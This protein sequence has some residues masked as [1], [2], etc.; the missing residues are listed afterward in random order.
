M[1]EAPVVPAQ[2]MISIRWVW[3]VL[4]VLLCAGGWYVSMTLLTVSGGAAPPGWLEALCRA[5]ALP[6][7]AG[8][9]E[10]V[11]RSRFAFVQGGTAPDTERPTVGTPWAVLGAAYF[12]F[13]GVWFLFVGT[14]SRGQW[15]WHLIPLTVVLAGAAASS[16]LIYVMASELKRWCGGCLVVHGLNA[17]LLL[18]AL[19]AAPWRKERPA[20]PAHPRFALAAATLLAGLA[21]WQLHLAQTSRQMLAVGAESLNK[22]Y[23]AIITDPD[24]AR[25]SHSRATRHEELAAAQASGDGAAA[26]HV[27][28]FIDF[29][30]EMCARAHKLLSDLQRAYGERLSVEYRHYPLDQ[31][32]NA[33]VSRTV[34]PAGCAAAQA[35]EAARMAGGEAGLAVFIDVLYRHQ[36]ELDSQ[37]FE[38]WAAE[39]QL[40]P[41]AFAAALQSAQTLQRVRQDVDVAARVGV[42]AAPALF[43]D[44]RKVEYWLNDAAWQA[45]LND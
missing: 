41:E 28:A 44:G 33:H 37:R 43:L 16:Y 9:C 39:A 35:A 21:V 31:A 22:R 18:A 23:L 1:S 15:L 24:F 20:R 40:D 13:V 12:A 11:L 19:A 25:W 29:Q 36:R 45:L 14:P 34:H 4:A 2:R 3:Q 10:S 17:A 30:C 7:S 8:D 5:D 6:Q 42:A 38:Q 26:H 32:C 27:V